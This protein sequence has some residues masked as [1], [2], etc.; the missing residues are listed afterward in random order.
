[1][2]ILV[3]ICGIGNGHLSRQT[4]VINL[5]ISN[6]HEVVVATTQN[7]TNYFKEKFNNIKILEINIP[8]ISCNTGGID[9]DDSLK[10]YKEGDIDLFKSFLIF[11]RNVE[12]KNIT[13]KNPSPEKKETTNISRK[14]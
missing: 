11:S 5:L 3:G 13:K 6:K 2:K 10:R 8:W 9:F 7:N 4:N 1:M 12:N 14:L